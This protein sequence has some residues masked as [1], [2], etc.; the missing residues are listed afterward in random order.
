VAVIDPMTARVVAQG[1]VPSAHPLIRNVFRYAHDAL[2]I[3][4]PGTLWRITAT[5]EVRQ[6][7]LPQGF[8]ATTSTA[9]AR[10]LWL[11]DGGRLLRIDPADPSATRET[12]V[13]AGL[14][15]LLGNGTGLYGTGTNSSEVSILDT[16]TGERRRSVRQPDGETVMAMVDAG[17]RVWAIG[18]CGNVMRVPDG[19]STRVSDVSQDL[20][21]VA[22]LGSLWVGDEVRSEVVRVS[23][24]SGRVLARIPFVAADRDDPAFWIVAGQASVWVLDSNFADGVS[25]IDP[26]GNRVTRLTP[27][28]H[29]TPGLS[30]VV[31]GAPRR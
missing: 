7:A 24:R 5:G 18:N 4:Q 14:G 30:A 10:W 16:D 28:R 27:G 20:P 22:G 11:S 29:A 19:M 2:W 3:A 6:T 15:Q 9:T 17:D 13:P 26:T 25:R 12:A 1:T 8:T 23:L 31:S 21:A